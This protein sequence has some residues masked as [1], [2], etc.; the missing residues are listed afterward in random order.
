MKKLFVILATAMTVGSMSATTHYVGGDISLLSE[1][2][3]AG[4]TYREQNG[5][6]I[7]DLVPWLHEQGMNSMRVRLFVDPSAYSG[8][9]KDPNACQT[10]EY[11]KPL[12][13]RIVDA[14]MDLML[15]FHYSDTWADP[16]KQWT[17]DAWKD[18]SDDELYQKIYEYTRDV[19]TELKEDGIE[20]AFIQT[21]NE[22]SYGM[23]WGPVGTSA[24]SLKKVYTGNDA[25]WERFGKLL[26]QAI[27]ACREV[28][29]NAKVIIHTERTANSK[30]Q[31]GFYEEMETLGVDYDIIGLS[32]YPYFH[33]NLSVLKTAL[34]SLEKN[35]PDK[36]IMIVETGYAYKW[37]VPGTTIDNTSTWPYSDEG[38]NQF[39]ADLVS[40]LNEYS[41]VVG[42]YWWWPE[43]NAKDTS[44]SDWYNAALFDSTTG[45]VT[46]AL[47]TLC[48]FNQDSAVTNIE[49]DPSKSADKWYNI[50]GMAIKAPTERGIYV[51]N[52]K[53]V[54]IEN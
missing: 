21:G 16:V 52:G 41:H 39:A 28:C 20:P 50:Q 22:I 29:P 33:G 42:V 43:Y 2:E 37:E 1:Y 51:K 53:L 18:L 47:S 54:V 15:D 7:T 8:S 36:E 34:A 48:G 45:R 23:L 19:L 27:S 4:A 24:G 38:Q 12:C 49:A 3:E 25:N 31:K 11:I 44:L 10:L 32:Y 9:D 5:R 6:K 40:L 46:S 14:G 30:V 13:K 17:P 26:N 35:F